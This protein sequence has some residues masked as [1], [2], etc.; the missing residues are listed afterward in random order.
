MTQIAQEGAIQIFHEPDSGMERV[1]VGVV[2]VLQFEVLEYR[3]KNEYNCDI[4]M[5]SLDFCV[6]RWVDL[7]E[8]QDIN[9]YTASRTMTVYD[10]FERPLILFANNY[11]LNN[12]AEKYD[13]LKLV[14]ALDVDNVVT[15][16]E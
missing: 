1:I 16:K 13:D 2:G 15:V 9:K 3:L 6:A 8:D 7:K 4:R 12:F 11:T 5:E 10:R 14:E